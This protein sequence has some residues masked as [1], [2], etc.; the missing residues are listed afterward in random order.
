MKKMKK[1]KARYRNSAVRC[2]DRAAEFFSGV[3]TCSRC[4]PSFKSP[5]QDVVSDEEGQ[6]LSVLLVHSVWSA[7]GCL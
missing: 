2:G 7:L 6:R 3:G 1:F 4:L 5:D